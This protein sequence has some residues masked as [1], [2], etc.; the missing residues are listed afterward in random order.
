MELHIEFNP[1]MGQIIMYTENRTNLEVCDLNY[2][3][4]LGSIINDYAKEYI[5]SRYLNH[6]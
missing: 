2:F 5:A 6:K 4:E 1:T 3:S